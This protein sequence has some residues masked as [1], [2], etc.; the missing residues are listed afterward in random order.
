[1]SKAPK[2]L[3]QRLIARVEWLPIAFGCFLL[4]RLSRKMLL[5]L[6]RVTAVVGLFLDRK[7]RRF[8]VENIR[9]V[10]PKLS[11]RR[12]YAILVGCYRNFTRV[13]FDMFWFGGPQGAERVRHWAPLTSHWRTFLELSGPKVI[14]TAH[15]G[16]WEIG[17]QIVVS[18]GFPLLSVGSPLGTPETTRKLNAFRSGLGQEIVSSEGAVAPLFRTLR[19]GKNIALLA[20]QHLWHK[21]GGVWT[22]FLGHPAQLAPTPAFFA[23]RIPGLHIGIAFLRARPD[24]T[25]W[26]SP[27]T[28]IEPG[29]EASI[30]GLTQQIADAS[31]KLIRRYPTQWLFAYPLW[32]DLPLG[33]DGIGWP[34]YSR[35][36]RQPL[37]PRK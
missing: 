17:G 35:P 2:N 7:G 19:K 10:F 21:K 23:R 22:Q 20:D 3:K 14:V 33:C 36:Q 18:N 8:A 25:Y 4:P 12:R 30:E 6:V 27:P 1:M 28:V 15:H 9:F 5:R 24:G 26:C 29:T 32:R 11:E 13:L 16:N 31:A 34:A 37:R